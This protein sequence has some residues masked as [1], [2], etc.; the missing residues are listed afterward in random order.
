MRRPFAIAALAVGLAA[1]LGAVSVTVAA[2][3]SARVVNVYN[4][5]DYIDPQVLAQFSKDTGIRV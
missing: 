5:S 3:Q 2:A 1:T 4:W